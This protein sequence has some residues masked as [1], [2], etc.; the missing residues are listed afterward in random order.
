MKQYRLDN[1]FDDFKNRPKER[2]ITIQESPKNKILNESE[3][4]SQNKI[5]KE[6]D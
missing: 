3:D 4:Y 6:I 1:Q 2:T 5:N